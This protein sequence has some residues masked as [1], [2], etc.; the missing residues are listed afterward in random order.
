MNTNLHHPDPEA[1][2]QD[3]EDVSEKSDPRPWLDVMWERSP[4][5]AGVTNRLAKIDS[6]LRGMRC[7]NDLLRQSYQA[8]ALSRDEDVSASAVTLNAWQIECLHFALTVLQDAADGSIEQLRDNYLG[9]CTAGPKRV[10][11]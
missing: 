11:V 9:C 10:A 5:P 3:L 6:A 8:E 4:L 1:I 2:G 7:I